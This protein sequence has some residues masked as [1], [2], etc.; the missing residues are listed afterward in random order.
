MEIHKGEVFVV[1]VFLEKL[2]QNNF[3]FGEK[4]IK[5]V[6]LNKTY[7]GLK[8]EEESLNLDFEELAELSEACELID[9]L[10][11]NSEREEVFW[12][13]RISD[14][15][16]W[17]RVNRNRKQIAFKKYIRMVEND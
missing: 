7:L 4:Q 16:R 6:K 1:A 13:D 8:T 11:K 12:T 15:T 9:L 5:E 10:T 2:R 14:G 3:I 17:R